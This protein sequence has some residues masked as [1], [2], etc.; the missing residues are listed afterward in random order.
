MFIS[1]CLKCHFP[2]TK[3]QFHGILTGFHRAELSHQSDEELLSML[4]ASVCDGKKT[5]HSGFQMIVIF[6]IAIM[7]IYLAISACQKHYH[8]SAEMVFVHSTNKGLAHSRNKIL[9]TMSQ[10]WWALRWNV[11][12]RKGHSTV[13]IPYWQS[14]CSSAWSL[15]WG[16]GNRWP[17]VVKSLVW[18]KFNWVEESRKEKNMVTFIL[19]LMLTLNNGPKGDEKLV[20]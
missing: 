10:E 1:A 12:K 2:D 14:H 17:F 19:P 9:E 6:D 20:L 18:L 4:C 11:D 16:S 13:E 7:R 8:L 3:E 15:F 5:H